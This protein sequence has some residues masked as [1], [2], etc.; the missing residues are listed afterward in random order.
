MPLPQCPRPPD[1]PGPWGR[2]S[3]PAGR[4]PA[5]P[6]AWCCSLRVS[7][8]G[9]GCSHLV[10]LRRT[11]RKQ[12]RLRGCRGMRRDGAPRA[13]ARKPAG[14][15]GPSLQHLPWLPG[16]SSR[17]SGM[18]ARGRA[19]HPVAQG[20]GHQEVQASGPP[21]VVPARSLPHRRLLWPWCWRPRQL[22]LGPV[23]ASV[24]F[25]EPSPRR[26]RAGL[27]AAWGGLLLASHGPCCLAW[28]R[29]G[30]GG[31]G[32]WGVQ[33]P[34]FSRG[35]LRAAG[36]GT[37]TGASS[38][39]VRP[40]AGSLRLSPLASEGAGGTGLAALMLGAQALCGRRDREQCPQ[41]TGPC[42]QAPAPPPR[43]TVAGLGVSR[44]M[45]SRDPA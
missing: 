44:A 7:V 29:A 21:S 41:G 9:R 35:A 37:A 45:T 17:R 42:P 14:G 15:I 1:P 40:V 16:G 20:Q 34:V 27:R 24:L 11:W 43:A 3:C 22:P 2:V 38:G 32:S 28:P 18:P 23:P 39:Q 5:G 19:G 6:Q 13:S 25:C 4:C 10:Q 33:S 12:G 26:A 31:W 36:A 30:G 8:G